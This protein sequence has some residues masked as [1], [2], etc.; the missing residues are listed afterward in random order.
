[1]ELVRALEARGFERPVIGEAI[2]RLQREGWLDELAAARAAVRS[3]V[4]RYGRDRIRREL[5]ARG[6]S[7][8]TIDEAFGETGRREEKETLA[9]IH[10]RLWKLHG[11]L[12]LEKRRRRVWAALLR[13]GFAAAD[14]SEIMK[15]SDEVDRG[16]GEIP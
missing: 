9:V 5:A 2:G 13:R 3:R 1:V 10:R 7:G 8:E 11:R 15:G 6:F 14:V 12:P 4:S 16:S